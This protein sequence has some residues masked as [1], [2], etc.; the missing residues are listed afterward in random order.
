M[1]QN[2][3]CFSEQLNKSRNTSKEEGLTL[4][5]H[6]QRGE[7]SSTRRWV[8]GWQPLRLDSRSD[9]HCSW[10]GRRSPHVPA[11]HDNTALLHGKRDPKGADPI[12]QSPWVT[13]EVPK[14]Q[15]VHVKVL[16]CLKKTEKNKGRYNKYVIKRKMFNLNVCS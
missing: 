15:S 7:P 3:G 12:G 5:R 6:S 11:D 9:L 4:S 16:S 1:V 10:H 2:S 8:G 14:H 13:T